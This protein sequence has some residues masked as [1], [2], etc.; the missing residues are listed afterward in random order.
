[1]MPGSRPGPRAVR[2]GSRQ[3]QGV[4]A[5][6]GGGVMAKGGAE[7]PETPAKKAPKPKNAFLESLP[8]S[9]KCRSLALK[10]LQKRC[11]K[12]EAKFD[13]EFQALGKKYNDIYKP[14]L[15]KFQ[16]LTGEM[17]GDAS[18]LEGDEGYEEEEAAAEE[19]ETEGSVAAKNEGPNSAVP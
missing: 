10:T 15:A 19:G 5:C 6:R 9:V 12:I 4:A 18:T 13:K 3:R 7:G 14:L 11:D 8:N 1:Q 16:E 17:E 2:A